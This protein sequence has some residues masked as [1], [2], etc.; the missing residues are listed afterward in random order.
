[1]DIN[2]IPEKAECVIDGEKLEITWKS[3]AALIRLVDALDVDYNRIPP[4]LITKDAK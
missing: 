4:E 1:V 3:L 2:I